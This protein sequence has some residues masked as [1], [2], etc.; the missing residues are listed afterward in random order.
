VNRRTLILVGVT[1]SALMMI[2]SSA[3]SAGG[4]QGALANSTYLP[5]IMRPWP[6]CTSARPRLLAP[7]NGSILNTLIPVLAWDQGQSADA[8][9]TVIWVAA[10]PGFVRIVGTVFTVTGPG[11]WTPNR[12]LELGTY[13][14]RAR[15]ACG[16]TAAGPWTDVWSFSTT[17]PGPKPSRPTL[18]APPDGSVNLSP[19]VILR[20]SPVQSAE[21]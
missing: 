14:W 12:N 13:Y 2:A 11:S 9:G 15:L 18:A 10:D 16:G 6:P 1:A 19:P 8:V 21:C 3:T 20:W 7:A 4:P 17:S 5:L